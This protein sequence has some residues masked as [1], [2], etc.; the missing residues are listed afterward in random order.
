MESISSAGGGFLLGFLTLSSE[1]L[2]LSIESLTFGRA[3]CK[4]SALRALALALSEGG[5]FMGEIGEVVL[6]WEIM[7]VNLKYGPRSGPCSRV[8]PRSGPTGSF[9]GPGPGAGGSGSASESSAGVTIIGALWLD[10]VRKE[11]V[12]RVGSTNSMVLLSDWSFPGAMSD[13]WLS[14]SMWLILSLSEWLMLGLKSVLS[15]SI[16]MT[17]SVFTGVWTRFRSILSLISLILSLFFATSTKLADFDR[18]NECLILE[19]IS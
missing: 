1:V 12:D 5:M 13:W 14:L 16:E 4:L 3:W 10:W 15:C 8:D 18:S 2:V 11:D 6:L 7:G 17:R 19:S 9:S